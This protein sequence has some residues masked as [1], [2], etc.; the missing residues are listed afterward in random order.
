MSRTY[1]ELITIPTFEE[2][3]TYLQLFGTVGKET[4][5]FDRY[6]NQILYTSNKW[7]H[8]RD[9]VIVRDEG[10]DMAMSGFPIVG[11]IYVHHMEPITVEDLVHGEDWI[12]DPDKLVS[13]SYNTHLAIHYGDKDLLVLPPPARTVNDTCPWRH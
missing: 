3:F 8:V 11:A 7:R 12:F 9:E 10:N 6:L 5:G 2:R 13:V 1:R 4:F